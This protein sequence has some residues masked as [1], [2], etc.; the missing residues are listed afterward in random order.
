MLRPAMVQRG[1]PNRLG[2]DHTGGEPPGKAP[3]RSGVAWGPKPP[4]SGPYRGGAA[5]QSSTPLWSSMGAQ[6]A[7]EW[8]IPVKSCRATLHPAM[9]QHGGP[10]RLGVDHNGEELPGKASPRYGL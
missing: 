2:V 1:G 6:T 8:I 10:H 5:R 9:A 7:S 3:P 4:P